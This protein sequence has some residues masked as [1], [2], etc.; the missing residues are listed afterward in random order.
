MDHAG[1]HRNA[2]AHARAG[3]DGLARGDELARVRVPFLVV[4]AP[5]DP[6]NPP[7]HAAY[8]AG[9][10]PSAT[11]VTVP[12]MGHALAPAVLDPFADAVE[13]HTGAVPPG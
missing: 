5:E 10:I 4:E 11:L 12:G 7:P 3:Q 1:T 6:I 13:A 8:L 2:A 9:L